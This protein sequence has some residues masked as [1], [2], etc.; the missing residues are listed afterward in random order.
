MKDLLVYLKNY[1]KECILAPLFKMLEASFEL[2]VPLVV[3][4]LIDKGILFGDKSVIYKSFVL[5]VILGLVGLS[6]SLTAQFF[7]AK[8]A[9]N[10]AA[11]L[12]HSL[13][14]HILKL[15]FPEIDKVGTSTLITRMTSDVN[16]LQNGVNM[17]LRL[18]LRSPFVVFGAMIMAF[19]IDTKSALIFLGV[20]VALSFVVFGLMIINIVQVKKVQSGLEGVL[21]RT[22]ENLEG[23]RVIRAFCKEKEE[24]D[25]FNE[26][27]NVL[28]KALN[29][30]GNF[31]AC[32]NPLTFVI[33]NG[34]IIG[35]IYFDMIQ[36]KNG[37]LSEGM[38]IALY[39]YMSQILVELIKLA[40]LI[41]LIIKAVACGNRVSAIFD[42]K[43]SQ[44]E[45]KYI[46]ESGLS[47]KASGESS[48]SSEN[49][50]A[51]DK[52][53][54]V[55][56]EH[57]SFSYGASME[58]SLSDIDISVK[59]GETVGVIGGTGSGKTSLVGMIPRFYDATEGRVFV[60]GIDVKDYSFEDLR[61]K[62]GIVMQK[63]V[64]FKGSIK[65]N[66]LWG[67]AQ[68]EDKEVNKAIVDAQ[69][70]D[71]VALK[72]GIDATVEQG[73]RNYSGGQRQRLSIARTLML[74]PQILILDDSSSALDYLTDLNLRKAIDSLDYKPTV[75]IVSQ[76][77]ASV[78][79]ADKIVVMDDGKIVGMDTHEK[80]LKNCEVYREIYESQ[81]GKKEV[82]A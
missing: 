12:R 72:G 65:S 36:V 81:Y 19:T 71:V 32:L 57:V 62:V 11:D 14:D 9:V 60:D 23:V 74:K 59:K 44:V 27:N 30:A 66:L 50:K 10:F 45:N 43:P 7:A 53:E 56:F 28:I 47:R 79:N 5:L 24:Y 17:V 16:Q 69:A 68:A 73:G 29:K 61:R 26:D 76:R 63:S 78:L 15:G 70:E 2:F 77:C 4:N 41:V 33:I 3:A 82:F 51:L 38:V 35:L 64:L 42:V 20:I 13:F 58:N 52:D 1:K 34:A 25:A 6:A 40:N 18:F 31:S 54:I 55:R 22:R 48:V 39:N 80:L 46:G 21:A 67:D 49:V 75:F 8:A 37:I